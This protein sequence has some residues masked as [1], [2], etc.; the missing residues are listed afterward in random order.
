ML[1]FFESEKK[2]GKQLMTFLLFV[3]ITFSLST[4]SNLIAQDE[5]FFSN[6]VPQDEEP[7]LQTR[8]GLILGAAILAGAGAGYAASKLHGKGNH[9]HDGSRGDIGL[10]GLPGSR[11]SCGSQGPIGPMGLPG[12]PGPQGPAGPIGP[13]GLT[14]P[15][16]F[17]GPAGPPFTPPTTPNTL[18]SAFIGTS[19]ITNTGSFT[20]FIVAP[21]GTVTSLPSVTFGAIGS[22]QI[23]GVFNQVGEYTIGARLDPGSVILATEEEGTIQTDIN[24]I[25]AQTC[26]VDFPIDALPGS[27]VTCTF[28]LF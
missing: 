17:V 11:G 6:L 12:I 15:I 18:M 5:E 8:T 14:G 27:E 1:S 26:P 13:M 19:G 4:P 25:L 24:G 22:V 9:G 23:S 2:Y 3:C 28:V 10:P 7:F 16:G 21:D 20:P